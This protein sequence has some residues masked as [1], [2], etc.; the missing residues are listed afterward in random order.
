MLILI[1]AF[2]FSPLGLGGGVLYLPILHYIAG[3]T[4]VDSILGSLSMVWMV[5]LGSSIAHT[6]SGHADKEVAKNGRKTA[7]PA[8]VIGT[9]I[10]W[11]IIEHVSDMVIKAF[12]A[13]S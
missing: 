3:W 1:V 7:V 13:I 6:K 4:I 5:A 10:A 12:A 8:A 9:V 2:A 11:L